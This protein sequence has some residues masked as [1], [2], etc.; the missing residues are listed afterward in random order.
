MRGKSAKW[1]VRSGKWEVGSA[2]CEVR[3]GEWGVGKEIGAV[4]APGFRF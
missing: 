3:S 2:K 1:E 4:E